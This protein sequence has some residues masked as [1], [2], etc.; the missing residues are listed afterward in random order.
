MESEQLSAAHDAECSAQEL[1]RMLDAIDSDPVAAEQD[2][3]YHLIGD[4]L[5][6]PDSPALHVD[7]TTSVMRSVAR[8][9][10]PHVPADGVVRPFKTHRVTSVRAADWLRVVRSSVAGVAAVAL[11]S[12]LVWQ[13]ASNNADPVVA[14]VFFEQPRTQPQVV[15][16]DSMPPELVDYLLAHRQNSV[17]GSMNAGS[18]VIR[19]NAGDVGG[20]DRQPVPVQRAGDMDWVR[21]WDNRPVYVTPRTVER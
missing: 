21:L 18:S 14:Y 8:E 16:M 10:V 17:A 7:V 4:A 9:S 5:R 12:A 2:A 20:A 6:D 19:A 3:L 15:Q 11:L 13:G 1:L